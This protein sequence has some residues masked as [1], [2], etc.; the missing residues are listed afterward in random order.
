MHSLNEDELQSYLGRRVDLLDVDD[1][2]RALGEF[3]PFAVAPTVVVHTKY[4]S[5]AHGV[6]AGDYGG[7]IT[8]GIDLASTRYCHGDDFTPDDLAETGRRPGHPGGAAFAIAIQA[9]LG[10]AVRCVPGRL[11]EVASPTTIG[12]GDTFVGGFLAALVR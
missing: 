11:L 10:D 1:V 7:A 9:R 12:L 2:A 5:L 3:R 4:W 6:R 8:G